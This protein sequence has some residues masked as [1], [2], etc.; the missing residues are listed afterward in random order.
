M[1]N[2][3]SRRAKI[4]VLT[5]RFPYPPVGGDKL[6]IYNLCKY[7][8]RDFDLTLLSLCTSREEMSVP[9]PDDGVF[10]QVERVYHSKLK[11]VAGCLAAMPTRKPLQVGY[12]Y[13]AEF[14]RR[15]ERFL[16]FNDGVLAHLIRTGAYLEDCKKAKIVEMT[17]AISLTYRRRAEIIKNPFGALLYGLEGRRLLDFERKVICH[18]DLSILVSPVDREYLLGGAEND[19]VQ[20]CSNGVDTEKFP[21]QYNPDGKTIV[22][23]GNNTALHNANAISSFAAKIFPKIRMRL[24]NAQLKVIG[25]IHNHLKRSLERQSGVIV[26]GGVGSVP[27][28]AMQATCGICPVLWG[29]GVQN[30]MLEY[31]SLGIPAV[32]SPIG[33]EGIDAK[34]GV[35][36]LIAES[37]EEWVNQICGLLE[38]P[39]SGE[40]LAREARKF[41]E[42]HH[43]WDALIEPI[44]CR[45]KNLMLS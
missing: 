13:S 34:P 31:M 39:L 6:R 24:P 1:D 19:K 35:H 37:D 16:P 9:V 32:T 5:P 45:I 23:I 7:L 14:A 12:Y 28:A 25:K 33:L 36:L 3:Q 40:M 42:E 10:V 30:K 38:K 4:V 20:V 29:A 27:E 43:S 26:T 44:C 17:D 8:S 41:V 15:L 18:F 22:F 11:S 2:K 21:Y